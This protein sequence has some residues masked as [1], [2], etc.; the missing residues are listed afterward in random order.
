MQFSQNTTPWTTPPHD[1][2]NPTAPKDFNFG[3]IRIQ[4]SKLVRDDPNLDFRQKARKI[5]RDGRQGHPYKKPSYLKQQE[6]YH[7]T[8]HKY[9]NG[10]MVCPEDLRT[11][12]PS[13][14]P[15]K[16]TLLCDECKNPFNLL[17][18]H[19]FAQCQCDNEFH[20]ICLGCCH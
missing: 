19:D 13:E 15:E 14:F 7:S 2:K 8:C 12:H 6:I 10:E 20:Q 11:P 5:S 18:S 9:T 3:D 4:Q 1:M 16:K 17:F